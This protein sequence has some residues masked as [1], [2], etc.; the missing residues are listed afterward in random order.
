MSLY[1]AEDRAHP[2][3]LVRGL[4]PGELVRTVQAGCA[5]EQQSDAVAM[6]AADQQDAGAAARSNRLA[7]LEQR[8]IDHVEEV[9][10]HIHQSAMPGARERHRSDRRHR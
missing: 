4:L 3:P 2:W 9:A 5:G 6:L 8:K 7:R 1:V 10:A